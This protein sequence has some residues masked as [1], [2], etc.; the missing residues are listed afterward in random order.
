MFFHGRFTRFYLPIVTDSYRYLPLF[1][2]L[3]THSDTLCDTTLVIY[4]RYQYM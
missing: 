3:C 2:Y 4:L 1:T